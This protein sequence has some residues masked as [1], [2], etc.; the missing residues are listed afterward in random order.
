MPGGE[1]NRFSSGRPIDLVH[2]ATQTMG[3]RDLEREVLSMFS[4]QA[5]SLS[6]SLRG[7]KSEARK[8]LAHTLKG[9]A[10]GVGAFG[11]AQCAERIEEAPS[12]RNA[13]RQLEARVAEVRDFIASISR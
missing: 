7:A 10:R 8:R 1:T 9:S 2:L 6:E 13:M 5:F 11:L 4:R 3:D 12:D